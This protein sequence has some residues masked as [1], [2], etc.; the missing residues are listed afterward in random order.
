M[1]FGDAW[2]RQSD[3][4]AIASGS[5]KPN[6]DGVLAAGE[7]QVVVGASVPYAVVS[8]ASVGPFVQSGSDAVWDWHD[9]GE[10]TKQ[11]LPVVNP[12]AQWYGA[13]FPTATY[14]VRL[15]AKSDLLGVFRKSDKSLD[16]LGVVSPDQ[17]PKQTLAI[18]DPPLPM[19]QFP[20]KPDSQWT[21]K[22]VASGTVDGMPLVW[23]ETVQ[24]QAIGNGTLWTAAGVF[25]VLAVRGKTD[26]QVGMVTTTYRS[27]AMVTECYGVVGKADSYP[28]ETQADFATAAELRYLSL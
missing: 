28:N 25:P 12:L 1:S 22:S 23:K 5:C 24:L 7:F 14:A 11:L 4:T 13:S 8:D 6:H 27:L 2:L 16:L 18:Y 3:A 9:A 15:T 17:G 26:K 20:L 10:T 19:L 21:A